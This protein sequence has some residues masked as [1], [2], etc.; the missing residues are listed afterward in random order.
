MTAWRRPISSSAWAVAALSGPAGGGVRPTSST[1]QP[2]AAAMAMAARAVMPRAPPVSRTTASGPRSRAPVEGGAG[3]ST[4][5]S[6]DR[7]P[8]V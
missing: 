3:A 6:V 1:W 7:V 8:L 5:V 4:T 2:V